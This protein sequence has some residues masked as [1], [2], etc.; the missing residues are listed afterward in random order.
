[1]P[2]VRTAVIPVAGLGTRFYLPPNHSQRILFSIDLALTT[3]YRSRQCRHR[4]IVFVTA[5]G[6]DAMID[7][8]DGAPAPEVILQNTANMSFEVVEEASNRVDMMPFDSKK[9]WDWDMPY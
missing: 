8:Y 9:H 2:T 4:T 6:K 1:M 7:Y 5:R 3:C